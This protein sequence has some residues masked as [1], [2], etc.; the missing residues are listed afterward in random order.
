MYPQDV[1]NDSTQ[2]PRAVAL[3][4]VTRASSPWNGNA[5]LLL[6]K[7]GGGG[8]HLPGL[9]SGVSDT[10]TGHHTQRRVQRVRVAPASQRLHILFAQ[11]DGIHGC[12]H[13][14]QLTRQGPPL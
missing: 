2:P 11:L 3:A 12:G 13:G 14:G 10:D 4:R 1:D 8:V 5:P 9:G 6:R 7:R